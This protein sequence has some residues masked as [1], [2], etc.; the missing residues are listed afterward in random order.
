M[1]EAW[2]ERHDAFTDRVARR[3]KQRQKAATDSGEGQRDFAVS[4]TSAYRAA[5]ASA[6]RKLEKVAGMPVPP[7]LEEL[8]S[9]P[10][11]QVSGY[12]VACG[13]QNLFGRTFSFHTARNATGLTSLLRN[14]SDDH[15]TPLLRT[16]FVVGF[17]DDGPG[18]DAF[19]WLVVDGNDGQVSLLRDPRGPNGHLVEPPFAHSLADALEA[20]LDVGYAAWYEQAAFGRYVADIEDVLLE[21][22]VPRSENVWWRAVT[23]RYGLRSV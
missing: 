4:V 22:L 8:W 15:D 6:M 21:P 11:K 19:S 23:M 17:L 2:R 5:G 20:A 7:V 9:E 1:L 12:D 10:V 18:D 13:D 3:E 16:G 14:L